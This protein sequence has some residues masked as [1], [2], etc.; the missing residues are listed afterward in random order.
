M[1]ERGV[2]LELIDLNKG[3][4]VEALDRLIG[5]RDYKRF[6]NSRNA[7]YREMAMKQNPP[8]RDQALQLMSEN[9]NLIKRPVVV[10]GGKI[11]L[12]FDSEAL[13]EL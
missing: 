3:L 8:S 10:A 5:E 4:S 13:G 11:V 1:A 9:P 12:G 6:L 2:E 7:L